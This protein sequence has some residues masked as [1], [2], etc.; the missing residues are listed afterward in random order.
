M[1]RD[2]LTGDKQHGHSHKHDS[3]NSDSDADMV[4]HT[5][6]C[7]DWIRQALM[8]NADLTLDPTDDYISFGQ[9]SEH[10]CRDFTKILEWTQEH[11]Y[12]GSLK[13]LDGLP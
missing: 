8:C 11:R 9:D 3:R 5:M 1:I 12:K 13:D 4:G 7:I 10:K 2:L 6:H